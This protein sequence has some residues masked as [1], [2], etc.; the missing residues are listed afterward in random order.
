MEGDG[1][2]ISVLACARQ[3]LG[4][5]HGRLEF[6]PE[7]EPPNTNTKQAHAVLSCLSS[8]LSRNCDYSRPTQDLVIIQTRTIVF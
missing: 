4:G 7:E 8:S 5:T 1:T 6:D 2:S 3:P